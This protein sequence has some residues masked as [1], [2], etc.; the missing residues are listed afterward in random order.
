MA[1]VRTVRGRQVR[2]TVAPGL[3]MVVTG[4]VAT[5]P[6]PARA[7]RAQMQARRFR[8]TPLRCR[9]RLFRRFQAAVA[10]LQL[11]EAVVVPPARSVRVGAAPR[12]QEEAERSPGLPVRVGA[13]P[14]HREEAER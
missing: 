12:H 2:G 3:A 8:I 1:Q 11:R 4:G 5:R 10:V 14:R 7:P 13:A 9:P 6:Q